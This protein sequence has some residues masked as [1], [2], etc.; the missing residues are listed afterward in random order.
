[1]RRPSLQTSPAFARDR[2]LSDEQTEQIE[3]GLG[4]IVLEAGES[5]TAISPTR[6]KF[7][8]S[9]LS[10]RVAQYHAE[11]PDLQGIGREQLRLMLEP[12][13]TKPAFV[14]ALQKLSESGEIALEGAFVRLTSHQVR[15]A[16]ADEAAWTTIAALLGGDERFRPPR[17]RDIAA[18][19]GRAERDVRR[20]LKLAS[21]LG[22]VDEIAHDHFF[23]RQTVREMVVDCG[24]RRRQGRGRLVQRCRLS[25]PP[26]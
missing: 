1:M 20:L 3:A 12:R 17:V 14:A 2:T 6:W 8:A 10:E 5:Q 4:L 22:W 16:P 11:N 19:T 26:R 13:L 25:R 18:A 23:L 21:R 24:R 15:L 9:S 7:F